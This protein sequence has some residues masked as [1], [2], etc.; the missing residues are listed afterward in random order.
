MADRVSTEHV[1]VFVV[2]DTQ[3]ARVSAEHV[4]VFVVPDTQKAQI[5]AEHVEVFVVPDTQKAQ[6]SAEYVEVF[7]A[8]A[9]TGEPVSSDLAFDAS[10]INLG[11]A[12]LTFDYEILPEGVDQAGADLGIDYAIGVAG[13]VHKD[14]TFSA[15]VTKAT[16]LKQRGKDLRIGWQVQA[17][18]VIGRDYQINWIIEPPLVGADL[19]INAPVDINTVAG[20]DLPFTF[21]VENPRPRVGLSFD[22][23]IRALVNGDLP[24]DAGMRAP[25]DGDLMIDAPIEGATVSSDLTIDFEIQAQRR[26]GTAFIVGPRTEE[27]KKPR[28]RGKYPRQRQAD[29]AF[30]AP[31]RR[32]ANSDFMVSSPILALVAASVTLGSRIARSAGSDL[33][34]DSVRYDFY[35][36]NR[37]VLLA[38]IDPDLVG[39]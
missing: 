28:Q 24:F 7:I 34:I 30:D 6:I 20:A 39:G 2:P 32:L 17:L 36:W 37:D 11:Q 22:A 18:T 13:G 3:K 27:P 15:R 9:T 33:G 1:E 5:S 26:R 16:K 35:D 21:E 38:E 23:T 4:E 12:S 8:G 25:A 14:L 19:D 31:I 10:I 29:L